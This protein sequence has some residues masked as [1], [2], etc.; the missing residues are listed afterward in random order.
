MVDNVY[1]AA[2]NYPTKGLNMITLC[3][4]I[5]HIRTTYATILQPDVDNNMTDF[6][7]GFNPYLP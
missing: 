5:A 6:H 4:L 7:T 2:L 1:Y 3:D